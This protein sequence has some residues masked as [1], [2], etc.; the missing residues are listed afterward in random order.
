MNRAQALAE[1]LPD[2][3][4]TGSVTSLAQEV[5]SRLASRSAASS[6][7]DAASEMA[8]ALASRDQEAGLRLTLR[9]L[10]G[11]ADV[12]TVYLSHLA[13]ACRIL[14]QR[15]QEDTLTS[16]QVTI[17]A[18]RVYAI[19]RGIGSNLTPKRWPDG[20]HAVFATVPGERHTLGI[21]MV[22]DLFRRDG[23]LID[24]KVGRSHNEL[25]A[26]LAETDFTILG[27]SAATPDMLP[28][29]VR[30]VAAVRV[31]QPHVKI[32]LSGHLAETEPRLSSL[33]DADYVSTKLDTLRVV[34]RDS[35]DIAA[36]H[37]G[38][39]QG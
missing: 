12:E 9:L 33:T 24:L 2:L 19:M 3:L 18:A 39:A 27:L 22:A 13:G 11:G 23:W 34:M 6:V 7:G 21:T 10:S 20:R 17:A 26:E 29:L 38:V 31:S 37:T 35:H 25:L 36:A 8:D 4:P 5:I 14:G 30:L 28:D 15:W 32:I 16:S 1:A